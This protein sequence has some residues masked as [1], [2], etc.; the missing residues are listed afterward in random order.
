MVETTHSLLGPLTMDRWSSTCSW[1]TV[2]GAV[3]V[4]ASDGLADRGRGHRVLVPGGRDLHPMLSLEVAPD[5]QPVDRPVRRPILS[6]CA[7]GQGCPPL[8]PLR[9]PPVDPEHLQTVVD[10]L[11]R[12]TD[13]EVAGTLGKPVR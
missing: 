2:S 3:G 12:C 5:V 6:M 10:L 1:G 8:A 9:T 13:P 4:A 11:R 7:A